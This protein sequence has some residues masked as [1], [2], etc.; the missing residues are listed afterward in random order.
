MKALLVL[1][2]LWVV[3][4]NGVKPV[5]AVWMDALAI[6][7]LRVSAVYEAR[8]APEAIKGWAGSLALLENAAKAASQVPKVT[9]ACPATR[10]NPAHRGL[11]DCEVPLVNLGGSASAA[12]LA[13]PATLDAAVSPVIRVCAALQGAVMRASAVRAGSLVQ[14]PTRPRWCAA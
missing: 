4:A 11:T 14:A 9:E 2:D 3:R 10:V 1:A 12:L 5:S 13:A 8:R 7:V 6:E